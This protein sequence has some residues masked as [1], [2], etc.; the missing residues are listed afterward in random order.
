[1]DEKIGVTVRSISASSPFYRAGLRRGDVIISING[2]KIVWE[3]DFLFLAADEF[4]R[5]EVRRGGKRMELEVRRRPG[6]FTGVQLVERPVRRCANRCI[7]CFIDQM[8]AGLRSSLYVKDE[9]LRFS[10]LNGNYVTM[11]SLRKTDL[12]HIVRI[13]LSPLYVSVHATD[14][15]VRRRML[16]N[17]K[18]PDIMEQLS[19]LASGGIMFHT[20]IVVCPSW[21]DG[22]T[23]EKSIRDLMSL[24]DA[25]RS[26][27]V[28]PVGLTRFRSFELEPVDRMAAEA[29]CRRLVP[30][31]DRYMRRDGLRRLFLADEFFVKAHLPIP[32]ATYYGDYPQI[33]N[34]VGLVRTLFESWSEARERAGRLR[35]RCARVRQKRRLLV[36]SVSA[37]PY[38]SAIAGEF[39]ELRPEITVTVL[40]IINLFFGET[41]TVAGLL[42]ASDIIRQVKRTARGDSVDGIIV[43]SVI[44]NHAG[45]TLDGFSAARISKKIEM[46][47]LIMDSI[48]ELLDL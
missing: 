30:L 18:A 38:L 28:V 39:M 40:P 20:Q 24:G 16:C 13:G 42:T 44:F 48:G 45:Y 11:S 7:F 35:R 9:D 43:P 12:D 46:P 15:V 8:P 4:L 17:N 2:E 25:V 33:E 36:T 37:A 14:T 21:N 31:S 34:G 27:A 10:L 5:L 32:D 6:D 23:L 1:M 47:V 22:K 41:I 19:F 3:L 29:V 26:I